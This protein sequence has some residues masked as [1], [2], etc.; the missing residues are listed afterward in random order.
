MSKEYLDMIIRT[1]DERLLDVEFG[2]SLHLELTNAKA[3][4][5]AQLANF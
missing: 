3:K 4:C 2:S 1:I 5:V